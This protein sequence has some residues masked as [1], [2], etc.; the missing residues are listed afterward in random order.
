[1]FKFIVDYIVKREY[2]EYVISFE[3]LF[4][5]R[6]IGFLDLFGIIRIE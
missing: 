5:H 2:V 6:G 4:V 1:M 3:S